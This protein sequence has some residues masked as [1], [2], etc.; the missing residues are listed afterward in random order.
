MWL[1]SK[2][3]DSVS[4]QVSHKPSALAVTREAGFRM[5]WRM[6]KKVKGKLQ[7]ILCPIC[8]IHFASKFLIRTILEKKTKIAWYV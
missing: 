4:V 8:T 1:P 7:T 3:K 6:Q 5:L 2:D